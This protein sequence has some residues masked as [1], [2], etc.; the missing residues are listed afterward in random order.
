M[1]VHMLLDDILFD[2]IRFGRLKNCGK[3]L[4][5]V[6]SSAT[7]SLP[8]LFIPKWPLPGQFNVLLNRSLVDIDRFAPDVDL[9]PTEDRLFVVRLAQ[10]IK[11]ENDERRE[12]SGS[13]SGHVV[14]V[15]TLLMTNV[16]DWCEQHCQWC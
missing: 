6:K 8:L 11:L 12:A 9:K 1:I 14:K 16:Y 3:E 15:R 13:P 4:G 5:S 10:L 7:C 2:K